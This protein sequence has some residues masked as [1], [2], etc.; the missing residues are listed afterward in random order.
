MR[1]HDISASVVFPCERFQARDLELRKMAIAQ[2]NALPTPLAQSASLPPWQ[3]STFKM[4]LKQSLDEVEKIMHGQPRDILCLFSGCGA[5]SELGIKA[6]GLSQHFRVSQFV[7]K[8]KYRQQILRCR[9]PGIPIHS[10]IRDYTPNFK[11]FAIV[12]GFPCR[13]TSGAGG[14]LGLFNEYSSLWFEMLRIID[15]SHPDFVLIENCLLYT[16]PSPRD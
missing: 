7:E 11:P 3:H 1:S 12:G 8:D 13:G 6:A 4:K 10:D 16:S 5:L 2:D 15:Q 9:F 14:R